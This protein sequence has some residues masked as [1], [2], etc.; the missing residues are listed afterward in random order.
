MSTQ[1][2]VMALSLVLLMSACATAPAA[3]VTSSP[4]AQGAE[5]VPNI[6][7]VTPENGSTIAAGNVKV[8]VSVE[9]FDLVKKLGEKPS[10]GEGHAMYYLDAEQIPTLPGEAARTEKAGSYHASAKGSYTWQDVEP[11]PHRFAVQLV[12]ND[13]TPLEPPVTS[14]TAVTVQ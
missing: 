7:V 2:W 4:D 10:D 14:E 8:S 6:T 12:N 9:D 5:G 11:G 3:R 13:G 1:R